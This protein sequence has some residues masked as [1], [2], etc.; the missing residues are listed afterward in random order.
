MKRIKRAVCLLLAA[1]LLTA[2]FALPAAALDTPSYTLS[3]DTVITAQAAMVVY[4][5]ASPEKDAVVYAKNVDQPLAPA[6]MNRLMVGYT[7][8]KLAEEKKLDLD[9]A[10]GTY[11]EA[12]FDAIAGT[13]IPTAGMMVG[14]VWTLRDLVCVSAIQSAGDVV[15]TLAI[16]L[17]GSEAAFVDKMNALA[18][19]DLGCEN[20]R[21][22]N[23]TGLDDR[24]QH[25][26]AADTYRIMRG[27]MKYPDLQQMLGLSYC[28]I[29][30]KKG[31]AV[32]LPA[33]TNLLRVSTD[34]YYAPTLFGRSGWSDL[35]GP[36]VAAVARA[37]GYDYMVVVMGCDG[38]DG[39]AHFADAKALF[40]W[41]FRDLTLATLRTKNDP[42][43]S[44]PVRLCWD[45][46]RVQLVPSAD[47]NAVIP[48]SLDT[49]ALVVKAVDLP[50]T[51]L[52]P[53]EKGQV[54]GKAT[55]ST[56]DG[57]VIARCDLVADRALPRSQ[58]LFV[59]Y[60]VGR[61]FGSGWFWGIFL[62]LIAAIGGYILLTI[63]HNR[64]RRRP[65]AKKTNRSS[66]NR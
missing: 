56:P 63:H 32:T 25:S 40:R 61:F 65:P 42:V 24:D 52:A 58:W 57:Q 45:D 33:S 23:V 60:G 22:T 49:G 15:E 3:K 35:T 10:T 28:E 19:D 1:W 18:A 38:Q 62:L 30:P 14:D 39:A 7:A 59:W 46:D 43:T 54:L 64:T 20:T 50:D 37:D 47:V 29:T 41:A 53:V 66:G 5:G 4:L 55:F 21:F 26:T 11:T 9:T 31:A 27:V 12:G 34:S 36:G 6:G 48:E 44:V 16:A 51:V 2:G 17:A 13:G 8:M